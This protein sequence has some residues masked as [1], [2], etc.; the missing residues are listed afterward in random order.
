M[1]REVKSVPISVRVSPEEAE[2]IARL[3]IQGAT[4]PSEKLR[5]IIGQARKLEE[6]PADYSIAL[7]DATQALSPV[8]RLLQEAETEQ[9][10]YS[11]LVAMVRDWLPDMLAYVSTLGLQRDDMHAPDALQ[12]FESGL[13][14]RLIRLVE[15]LF[16]Q[17]VTSQCQ[18]YAPTVLSERKE[19]IRELARIILTQ[20]GN[21]KEEL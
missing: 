4:T 1:V 17:A 6:A 7:M 15:A 20:Q 2:F 11:A 5:A 18:C 21:P 10:R 8:F 3:Q 12:V 13:A 14:D 9:Q 16:Q 19:T